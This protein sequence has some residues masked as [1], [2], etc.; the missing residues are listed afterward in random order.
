MMKSDGS[1]GTERKAGPE[2]DVQRT[3]HFS[4]KSRSIHLSLH[5][6]RSGEQIFSGIGFGYTSKEA[7]ESGIKWFPLNKGGEYRKWYGNNDYVVNYQ[8]DGI[9]GL[10]AI[11]FSPTIRLLR[12]CL[13]CLR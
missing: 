12:V 3:C 13:L 4:T 8:Y 2:D 10:K 7:A 9:S 5:I 11:R 6:V 1:E